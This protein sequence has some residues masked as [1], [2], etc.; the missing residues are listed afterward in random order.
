MSQAVTTSL[1][2]EQGE[3][4]PVPVVHVAGDLDAASAAPF[5]AAVGSV[6]ALEHPARL[7]LDLSAVDF[8]DSTGLNELVRAHRNLH[9]AGGRLVLRS[10]GETT[11]VL[12]DITRLTGHLEIE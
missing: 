10:P 8:L 2:F 5:A 4:G 3:D 7:V 6:I 12:L 11:R 1:E 9:A